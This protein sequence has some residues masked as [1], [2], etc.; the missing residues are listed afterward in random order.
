[1][2]KKSVI[3]KEPGKVPRHVHISTS[4]E[5]LQKIVGGYIETVTM[6]KDFTIICNEDGRICGLPYNCNIA[7]ADFFGTIIMIGIDGDDFCHCPITF[8]S[9]KKLFPDLWND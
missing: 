3:I 7:G 6:A 9:A 1:M 5:N 2:C 8:S 4:L